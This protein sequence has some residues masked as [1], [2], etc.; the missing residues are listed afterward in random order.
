MEILKKN[1]KLLV[2]SLFRKTNWIFAGKSLITPDFVQ[3]NWSFAGRSWQIEH[4]SK[5]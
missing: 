1:P 2:S 3:S 5:D 4:F